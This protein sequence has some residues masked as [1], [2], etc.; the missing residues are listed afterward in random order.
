MKQGREQGS[1]DIRDGIR[2]Y[3]K[4]DMEWRMRRG[5]SGEVYCI[6]CITQADVV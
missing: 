2:G 3:E 6:Y 4:G 5:E 1:Q